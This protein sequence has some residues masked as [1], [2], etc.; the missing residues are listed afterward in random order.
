M[1]SSLAI[2]FMFI[3]IFFGVWDRWK[4]YYPTLLFWIIGNLI[5]DVLLYNY[6]VWELHPVGIDHILLPTH[7]TISLAITVSYPF[8]ASVFLGRFPKQI[9]K[10]VI[11]ILIW[12]LTFQIIE[13]IA[14]FYEGI[15]HHHGWSLIWSFLFNVI[16]FSILPIHQWKPWLAWLFSISTMIVL[17]II[18]NVP[19]P[20]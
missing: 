1:H 16:T 5:Y 20:K 19:L 8:M 10:R 14:Y 12:V 18:F 17:F 6:R 9:I 2:F 7:I 11:W 3:S 13:T 15:T 4:E